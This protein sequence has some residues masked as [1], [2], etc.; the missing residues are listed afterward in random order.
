MKNILIMSSKNGSNF[1]AIIKYFK[2]RNDI[3]FKLLTD[4]K[5]AYV[6][7]RAKKLGIE[8]ICLNKEEIK[9]FFLK[10]K[11]DFVV[12][13]GFFKILDKET[14]KTNTFIN[15]HPS[16]LP[17]YKGL[18]AIEYAYIN[19]DLKT[20]VTIHYANEFVDEGEIIFQKELEINPNWNLKKLEKEIHKLEHY[21]YPRI[22]EKLLGLNV[23]VIGGGAREHVIAKKIKDSKLLNTLYLADCN[24]GFSS[25]GNKI[26]YTDYENLALQAQ[27]R[28]IN[29]V[30]IGSEEYLANG[31]VD[32][33]NKFNIKTIGPDKKFAK[34]ESSKLFA[35]KI[36]A[37]YDIKTAPYKKITSKNKI[38]KYLSYFKNPVIKANGLAKG[39]GV[40]LGDDIDLIKKELNYYLNGKFRESSKIT[41]IEEKLFGDEVSLF[42]FWDGE[43]LL[44]FPL[45][46][47][48]KQN[49]K[50][51]NTGGLASI[52]PVEID[53]EVNKKLN[54]YKE[55][56][57]NLLKKEKIKTPFVI[58]SGLIITK[59]DIY[60]LEYN[61]R[62]GDPEAQSLLNY[63]QNDWLEIFFMCSIKGLNQIQLK[64]NKKPVTTVVLTS[65]GY[66]N[67][68]KKGVEI[69][70][71]HSLNNKTEIYFSNIIIA[72][73]KV[74]SNGGRVLSVT[75]QD[76]S[77]IY[78]TLNDI[79]FTEKEY[80]MLN[81]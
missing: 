2:N 50:G 32:V 63:I 20:G 24:D 11:F 64:E 1:E 44:H 60:V 81:V 13:A 28:N 45:C 46:K 76:R 75:S 4:N 42:S 21:Y 33:L 70:N 51:E 41:L 71:I 17:K 30:I 53:F 5:D 16:L 57:F 73:G 68:V 27:K 23:L 18:K 55:K 34:L 31:L 77:L 19:N 6:I 12:M 22:I 74:L 79:D 78:K 38:D 29:L 69:K 48:F 54:L 59:D 25:L 15:I 40:Y 66:P 35:K 72:D 7:K 80:K 67:E 26:E 14:I 36:M 43:N 52:C 62:L 9:D 3:N 10:N 61:V 65:K 56:L 47:D 8:Y 58:Y 37:K 49:E 39:K